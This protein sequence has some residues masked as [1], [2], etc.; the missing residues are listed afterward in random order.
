M[1]NEDQDN[2]VYRQGHSFT[3]G[4]NQIYDYYDNKIRALKQQI[5]VLQ[6]NKIPKMDMP[7]KVPNKPEPKK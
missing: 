6:K 2:Q 5:E 7:E 1:N 4:I 3:T